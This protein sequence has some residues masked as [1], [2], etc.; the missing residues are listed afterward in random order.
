MRARYHPKPAT[1]E[2]PKWVSPTITIPAGAMGPNDVL[3][4]EATGTW[5]NGHV[6]PVDMR[7]VSVEKVEHSPLD[8]ALEAFTARRKAKRDIVAPQSPEDHPWARAGHTHAD[9]STDACPK[10]RLTGVVVKTLGYYPKCDD[11]KRESEER[12][13]LAR[14]MSTPLPHDPDIHTR[15]MPWRGK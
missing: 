3:H 11:Y 14:A 9:W 7:I 5:V 6:G 13:K 12:G 4:I 2:P 8:R 15:V 10:C 1:T